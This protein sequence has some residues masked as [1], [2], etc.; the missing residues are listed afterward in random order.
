MPYGRR[1]ISRD[2]LPG[3]KVAVC[4]EVQG[5]LLKVKY[6]DPR[7]ES[8]GHV[9]GRIKEFTPAARKRMIEMVNRLDW[10]KISKVKFGTLTYPDRGY[11]PRK[12]ERMQSIS[13]LQRYLEEQVQRPVP[14]LWRTEWMPRMSGEQREQVMPHFHILHFD[15]PFIPWQDYRRWWKKAIGWKGYCRTEFKN[16]SGPRRCMYY[17]SKYIGKLSDSSSLVIAAYLN[18]E[19]DGR[20]W[21]ILRPDHMPWAPIRKFEMADGDC[22]KIV[23]AIARN[24]RPW[25]EDPGDIGY[26]V[27]GDVGQQI[28][29]FLESPLAGPGI[30]SRT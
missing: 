4:V 11:I 7:L 30:V 6:S 26:T 24:V 2:L 21:G 14:A 17:V 15:C 10:T 27:F 12:E 13:V 20:H 3:E 28:A 22:A 9:R 29:D 19:I 5:T 1:Y 23:R 16:A 18:N 8:V 25:P